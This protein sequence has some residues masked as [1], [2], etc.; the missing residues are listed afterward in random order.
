MFAALLLLLPAPHLAAAVH[1]EQPARPVQLSLKI[2]LK[3]LGFADP[4]RFYLLSKL[5]FTSLD[6]IDRDHLLFTFHTRHLIL[7]RPQSR[8]SD[9]GEVIRA[10]VF[11]VNSGRQG[12]TAEWRMYDHGAYLWPLSSGHFLLRKGDELFSG[13]TSLQLRQLASGEGK[14]V[15]VRLSPDRKVVLV[16]RE[17][18]AQP[19]NSAA[20][21]AN[22]SASPKSATRGKLT[23]LEVSTGNQLVTAEVSNPVD[24]PILADGFFDTS[25]DQ[26]TRYIDA[27]FVPFHGESRNLRRIESACPLIEEPLSGDALLVIACSGNV[28]EHV[29][30]AIAMNGRLLWQ[31][32]WPGNRLWPM[33]A[34]TESGT[35]FACSY[36]N[37]KQTSKQ[38][39]ELT[40]ADIGSEPV[41]VYD[42]VSGQPLLIIAAF[43]LLG[44]EQNYAI[45]PDGD[46]LAVLQDG[47]LQVYDLPAETQ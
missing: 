14:I 20:G 9:E 45:S 24:I 22:S 1:R 28:G 3:P 16:E 19:A 26:D 36:L 27:R 34:T 4:P 18:P 29:A 10:I 41:T 39:P 32:R 23:I 43:P 33:F 37:V 40:P 5:T 11:D 25:P 47:N 38:Q 2:P 6:F 21:A 12:A 44:S 46:R 15:F 8:T 30:A 31:Q 42:T 13:D 7:R 35:R 17:S